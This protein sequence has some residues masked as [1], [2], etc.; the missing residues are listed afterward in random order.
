MSE[1][2]NKIRHIYHGVEVRNGMDVDRITAG[3]IRDLQGTDVNE[4]LKS[5]RRA[6]MCMW[7]L[8]NPRNFTSDT[9][10]ASQEE[11]DRLLELN[12]KIECLIEDGRKFKKERDW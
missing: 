2:V 6:I 12:A 3:V 8:A 11:G 9:V 7:I 1:I 10:R 4:E 5:L